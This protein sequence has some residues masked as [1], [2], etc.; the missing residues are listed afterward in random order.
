MGLRRFLLPRIGQRR[1]LKDMSS[2]RWLVHYGDASRSSIF[3]PYVSTGV[4][5]YVCCGAG[6]STWIVVASSARAIGSPS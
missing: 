1:V 4:S 2:R 5:D 6:R 3:R